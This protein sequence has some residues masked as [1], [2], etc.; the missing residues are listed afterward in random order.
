MLPPVED[1]LPLHSKT[2]SKKSGI[3]NNKHTIICRGKNGKDHLKV[4]SFVLLVL[5]QLNI[6]HEAD[7]FRLAL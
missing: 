2:S 1:S 4:N 5:L 3:A 6:F 7:Y